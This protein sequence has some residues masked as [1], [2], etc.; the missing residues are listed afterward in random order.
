MQGDDAPGWSTRS[1]LGILGRRRISRCSESVVVASFDHVAVR[2]GEVVSLRRPPSGPIAGAQP[3]AGVH[4]RS[5][6]TPVQ[7]VVFGLRQRYA[8]VIDRMA[9][10]ALDSGER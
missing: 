6:Q 4:A 3:R 2:V 5:L 10:T 8:D 1:A 7:C 9:G